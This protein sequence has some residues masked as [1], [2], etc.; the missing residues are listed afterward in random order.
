MKKLINLVLDIAYFGIVTSLR[1]L[2]IPIAALG[3]FFVVSR[4]IEYGN[5]WDSTGANWQ[6]ITNDVIELILWSIVSLIPFALSRTV[7][8]VKRN[9]KEV[10]NN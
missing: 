7:T 3:M 5:A 8:K 1:I 6:T 10:E 9:K 4:G 2:A